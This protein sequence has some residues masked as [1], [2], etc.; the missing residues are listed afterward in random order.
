MPTNDPTARARMEASGGRR[1]SVADKTALQRARKRAG[2]TQEAVADAAGC[3]ESFYWRLERE[4]WVS[5]ALAEQIADV[6]GIDVLEAFTP[7]RDIAS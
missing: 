7:E 5:A 2:L 6:L 4:E 1:Y 3:H